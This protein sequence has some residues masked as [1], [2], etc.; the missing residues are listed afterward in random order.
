MSPDTRHE[1]LCMVSIDLQV[2]RI[3]ELRPSP[4]K[5][6]ILGDQI[7]IDLGSV[8]VTKEMSW[9]EI[10]EKLNMIFLNHTSEVSIGLRTKKTSKLDQD[11]PDAPNPFTLGISLNSIKYFSIGELYFIFVTLYYFSLLYYNTFFITI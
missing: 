3:S 2:P 6:Q 7:S 10:E 8:V 1:V 4:M 5:S 11:S 9:S